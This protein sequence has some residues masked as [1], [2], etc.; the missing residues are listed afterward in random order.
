MKL[1]LTNVKELKR[2]SRR[3]EEGCHQ[4]HEANGYLRAVHRTVRE[5]GYAMLL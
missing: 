2:N 5:E 4:L 3:N 1:T